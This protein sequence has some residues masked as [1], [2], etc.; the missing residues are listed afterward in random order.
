MKEFE[1]NTK[2]LHYR[3]ATVY[4]GYDSYY[5]G[6]DICSYT[7]HIMMG[8]LGILCLIIL[9]SFLSFAL[10]DIVVGTIFSIIAGMF[11]MGPIGQI[12]LII[13]TAI[14]ITFLLAGMVSVIK[15]KYYE[16][17]NKKNSA[18]EPDG[19]IKTAYKSWKDKYCIKVK[20]F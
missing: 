8:L 3:L 19:F 9:L 14:I 15:N 1:I 20:F 18:P 13:M 6:S 2:S 11:I 10:F 7:R 12:L 16:Y 17:K 5:R 4:G